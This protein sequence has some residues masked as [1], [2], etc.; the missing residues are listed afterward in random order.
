MSP[1]GALY[2]LLLV[3]HSAKILGTGH[4]CGCCR[5]LLAAA[6]HIRLLT[7]RSTHRL[8]R[9]VLA[10]NITIFPMVEFHDLIGFIS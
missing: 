6:R 4:Y 3:L 7:H 9:L 10:R 5:T 1:V 8:I 2:S